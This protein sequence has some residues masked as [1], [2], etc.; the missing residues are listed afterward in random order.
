MVIKKSIYIFLMR[1]Y[2]RDFLGIICFNCFNFVRVFWKKNLK[3]NNKRIC[4]YRI[5]K[6]KIIIDLYI[7]FEVL[8]DSRR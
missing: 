8:F 4:K 3:I 7:V 6:I 5:Y 1:K 2:I